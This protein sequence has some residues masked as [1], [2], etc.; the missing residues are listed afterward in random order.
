MRSPLGRRATH[1]TI[2]STNGSTAVA[3]TSAPKAST[4]TA[5]I[6][7]REVSSATAPMIDRATSTSL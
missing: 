1:Q 7:R 5:H 4:A 6:S 2:T 3:F